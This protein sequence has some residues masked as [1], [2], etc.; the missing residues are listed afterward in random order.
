LDDAVAAVD[1]EQPLNP[2]DE[3]WHALTGHRDAMDYV[4]QLSKEANY[5]H[6]EGTLLGMHFMMM[7]HDLSKNPGRY[8]PGAI[9]VTNMTTGKVVYEGPPAERVPDLMGQQSLR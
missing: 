8:R 5:S 7:K 6:N 1:G 4:I 9:H 2:A 3:N